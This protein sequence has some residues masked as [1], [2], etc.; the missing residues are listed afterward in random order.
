MRHTVYASPHP[1]KM[2]TLC[3][4]RH[5]GDNPNETEA[6]GVSLFSRL[7]SYHL[8]FEVSSSARNTAY[9]RTLLFWQ[10]CGMGRRV[11]G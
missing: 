9:V 3:V 7:Q 1:I 10:R 6:D 5:V 4:Q 11:K 8:P 2:E